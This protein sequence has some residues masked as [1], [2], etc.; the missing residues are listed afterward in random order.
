MSISSLAAS[1]Q[2][3]SGYAVDAWMDVDLAEFRHEN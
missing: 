2:S 3:S 1:A